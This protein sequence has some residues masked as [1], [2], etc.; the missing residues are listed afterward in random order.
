MKKK[1][2]ILLAVV[3]IVGTILTACGGG[4]NEGAAKTTQGQAQTEAKGQAGTDTD[5]AKTGNEDTKGSQP[6][7]NPDHV[8]VTYLYMTTE[9][10]DLGI[11]QDAVNEITI[12]AINVEVEFKPLGIGDSFTNYS[13]W[14]SSGEVVDLMMLAFQDIKTYANSGQ[15]EPLDE[16]LTP[17][18]TPTAVKLMD[19]FP[20]ATTV[21]G[22]IFGVTPVGVNY[23]NKPGLVFREDYFEETGYEKKDIYTM[24][25]LTNIFASV[26]EKHPE[27][28]PFCL[29]GSS[30]TAG[31]TYYNM[32]NKADI[33]GGN[34]I[35]GA[36]L[37]EDDEMLINLFESDEYK[38]W[39]QQMADWYDAGYLLPDAATTDSSSN[40]LMSSGKVACYAMH[41]KP[42]QFMASNA[43]NFTLTSVPTSNA[44]IGSSSS[45]TGGT[46]WVVPVTA[47]NPEAAVK[48][49]DYLFENHDLSNLIM[50]G[51]KDD[52]FAIADA[53][54][55][56]IEFANDYDGTTSPY[57][58]Q[59][60]L[61]GDRRYEYTFDA[62]ATRAAHDAFTEEAMSNKFK[63][64]GF[65]FDSTSV[66]NQ[67]IACQSVLDQYQKALETGSLG[68]A[69]EE[70]YN[71]MIEQLQTA[72]IDQ[73]MQECQKQFDT[74]L[75]K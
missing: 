67:I 56:L 33:P 13:L 55:G 15:I 73:V 45:G 65:V 74:F 61:W 54:N 66:S 21:Q 24:E 47:K 2:A 5:G 51:I 36:L 32:L 48:L 31:I 6:A 39:L 17:E 35:A 68:N 8:I 42:E 70:T 34:V 72:G 9:P 4:G 7:G 18:T 28:Y 64:Y 60:G 63:S 62:S 69:W 53:D 57:Y 27:S 29:L 16:L 59:L 14:I 49:L 1:C 44:Y 52:H 11:V 46:N 37:N 58:N 41:Q 50:Y 40:E 38:A 30:I 20:I 43:Y 3:M 75:G 25:D 23:G 71:K 26:K 19:E 10:A 22:E 12:P